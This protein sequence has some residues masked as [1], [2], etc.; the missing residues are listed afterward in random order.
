VIPSQVYRVR[1]HVPESLKGEDEQTERTHPAVSKTDVLY[2]E[3]DGSMICTRNKESWSMS[4]PIRHFP[5]PLL[6]KLC[7]VN[8]KRNSCFLAGGKRSFPI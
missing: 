2:V 3:T 1:D 6:P 8:S 4:L 5:I 7:G